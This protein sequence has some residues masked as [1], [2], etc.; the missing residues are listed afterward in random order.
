MSFVRITAVW[1]LLWFSQTAVFAADISR[2]V[3]GPKGQS[4][5]FVELGFGLNKERI[6]VAG[7][8]TDLEQLSEI[9]DVNFDFRIFLDT[10]LEWKG[11]FAELIHESF[12][13]A[14]LGYTAWENESVVF[15]LILTSSLGELDP[16]GIAGLES[17]EIREGAVEGGIRAMAYDGDNVIQFEAITDVSNTHSGFSLS[18]QFGRH[19]Q[20]RNW[21]THT[22]LGLRYFSEGMVNHYF[23][24]SA[25]EARPE[26]GVPFYNASDGTIATLE[27]GA[28]RPI[29]ENW[30][31]KGTARAHR[32]PDAM[33]DSPLVTNRTAWSLGLNAIYVF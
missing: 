31:F 15:D 11:F 18:W 23:D 1:C 13:L 19:W 30:V 16:S 6:A 8:N 17:L 29:N 14:T 25:N 33:L 3:R 27:F 24:V 4:S 32:L 21:A 12:G 20:L 5:S 26:I 9:D 28:T 22:L 2:D 10:R 7:Y